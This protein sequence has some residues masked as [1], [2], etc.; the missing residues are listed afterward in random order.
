MRSQTQ[1]EADKRYKASNRQN[2]QVELSKAE[3]SVINDF[4]QDIC[5]PAGISK[6]RFIFWACNYF[7]ERGELPPESEAPQVENDSD[8]PAED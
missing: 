4:I 6:A 5:K 3:A 1:K 8:S 7:I 2:I